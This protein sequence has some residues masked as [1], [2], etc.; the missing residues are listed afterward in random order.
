[1]PGRLDAFRSGEDAL[2]AVAALL[3]GH[4]P[5]FEFHPVAVGDAAAV[6]QKDVEP[7]PAGED[8]RTVAA[9]TSAQYNEFLH[10]KMASGV[11]NPLVHLADEVENRRIA[12]FA[13]RLGEHRIVL[14]HLFDREGLAGE[15]VS[16]QRRRGVLADVGATALLDAA[17][18]QTQLGVELPLPLRRQ[19]VPLAREVLAA[20]RRGAKLLAAILP[21]VFVV[22]FEDGEPF[23]RQSNVSPS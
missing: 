23:T 10:F 8:R 9:D 12:P 18:E 1:M 4:A 15:V 3:V 2:L 13:Q 7:F 16:R 17:V 19:V 20:Q 6:G 5:Y 11:E 14:H 22:G 21:A